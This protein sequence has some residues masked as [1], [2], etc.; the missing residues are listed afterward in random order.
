MKRIIISE[1]ERNQILSMHKRV[2]SE[3]YGGKTLI[4]I[5]NVLDER[6]YNIGT[7]GADGKYGPA[8]HAALTSAIKTVQDNL[9]KS[10]ALDQGVLNQAPEGVKEPAP[11]QGT[12]QAQD[13]LKKLD[14]S[15]PQGPSGNV[16]TMAVKKAS[17]VKLVPTK[18]GLQINTT[19]TPSPA[20]ETPL[21]INPETGLPE[22]EKPVSQYPEI[23]LSDTTTKT[24][25]TQAATASTAGTTQA[26]KKKNLLQRVF[27]GKEKQTA[28][29]PSGSA[30][31]GVPAAQA[32]TT[33]TTTLP[34][35][36]GT[37]R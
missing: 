2:I 25:T 21:K 33:Q 16:A 29:V 23:T 36:Q 10:M 26:P 30:R 15:E 24:D 6:G 19:S 27:G 32:S 22:P 34:N 14:S 12:Q 31:M 37:K 35:L 9:K 28:K 13:F 17:D 18:S 20:P 7:T 5:Q 11:A 8:T 3:S 4:D 1:S